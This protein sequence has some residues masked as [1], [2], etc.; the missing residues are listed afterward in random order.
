MCDGDLKW[1]YLFIIPC[2]PQFVE[3]VLSM[4]FDLLSDF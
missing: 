2:W 4:P 3:N 1:L